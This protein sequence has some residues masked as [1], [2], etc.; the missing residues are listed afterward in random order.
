MQSIKNIGGA[1]AALNEVIEKKQTELNSYKQQTN[2]S[3]KAVFFKEAEIKNLTGILNA[4]TETL[5]EVESEFISMQKE[6]NK[7][8]L[9]KQKLEGCLLVHGVPHWEI[10][11]WLNKKLSTIQ[12][13]VFYAYYKQRLEYKNQIIFEHGYNFRVPFL[14]GETGLEK[15]EPPRTIDKPLIPFKLLKEKALTGTCTDKNFKVQLTRTYDKN[16]NT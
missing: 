7:T 10:N 3:A 9:L 8:R 6:I 1:I 2:H 14:L 4:F 12:N 5:N 13:E 15:T 16:Q 11:N